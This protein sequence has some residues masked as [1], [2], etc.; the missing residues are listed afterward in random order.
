M[1]GSQDGRKTQE[2]EGRG[3]EGGD[4]DPHHAGHAPDHRPGG[5]AGGG[6]GTCEAARGERGYWKPREVRTLG[7][8]RPA[9]S[10][11]TELRDGREQILTAK[12]KTPVPGEHVQEWRAEQHQPH[13]PTLHAR[14]PRARVLW[15]GREGLGGLIR[16]DA[17]AHGN[18]AWRGAG[19]TAT[20]RAQWA[21]TGHEGQAEGQ[22]QGAAH[23]R[24]GDL[25]AGMTKIGRAHV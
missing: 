14:T 13:R 5:T 8:R 22:R 9:G 23:P 19:G 2:G 1:G 4:E 6:R 24:L 16:S 15:A 20:G 11:W 3:G 18:Q 10:Q 25:S 7:P 17:E 21:T 12:G